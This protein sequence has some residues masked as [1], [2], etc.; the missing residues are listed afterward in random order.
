[1]FLPGSRR[2]LSFEDLFRFQSV[3]FRRITGHQPWVTQQRTRDR[4]WDTMPG[5][6]IS[7]QPGSGSGLSGS[8]EVRS[9]QNRTGASPINAQLR[10]KTMNQ[11]PKRP[12]T[13][14][15]EHFRSDGDGKSRQ[16]P[17]WRPPNAGFCGPRPPKIQQQLKARLFE[18]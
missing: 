5:S 7:S 8:P 15:S 16:E 1:M 14:L 9:K 18:V 4:Y 12:L 11:H 3:D 17:V 6:R 13:K 10:Q 2:R